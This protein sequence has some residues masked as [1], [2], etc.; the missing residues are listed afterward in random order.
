LR[1]MSVIEQPTPSPLS[2]SSNRYPTGWFQIGWSDELAPGTVQHV[3]YFGRDIALW[4]GES[5]ELHATDAYCLHLGANLAVGGR[6]VGDELAC[7]FHGWQW[8]GEGRNTFIPHSSQPCKPRLQLEVWEVRDWC[9]AI[10]IWH[11]LAGRPPIW[12]PEVIDALESGRYYPI[13][14]DTRSSHKI[15]AHPQMVL[16]NGPDL[17]H[18]AFVHGG[19]AGRIVKYEFEEYAIDEQLA[20]TYGEGR[21]STWLTPN[22]PIEALLHSR[23]W[24]IGQSIIWWPDELGAPISFTQVTPIDETYSVYWFGI[25]APLNEDPEASGP[26]DRLM[27]FMKHQM[28]VITDDFPI[29]ENMRYENAAN[30]A[31]EEGLNYGGLRRWAWRFYPTVEDAVSPTDA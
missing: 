8:N 31:P 26:D 3:R 9:D 1:T 24:G 25:T 13:S 29:W 23:A 16:E 28:K 6:V 4:R 12:Q 14:A 21:K 19:S 2:V 10:I 7:P 18:V 20:V 22:G 30:F 15:K 17:F 5:G 11:D 27:R